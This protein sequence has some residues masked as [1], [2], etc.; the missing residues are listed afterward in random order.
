LLTRLLL[1]LVS[2]IFNLFVIRDCQTPETNESC[3]T[4]VHCLLKAYKNSVRSLS[5]EE[6]KQRRGSCS[7]YN[8]ICPA[9]C[10]I[11]PEYVACL[12]DQP[13]TAERCTFRNCNNFPI[14]KRCFHVRETWTYCCNYPE[15]HFW[16]GQWSTCSVFS[17]RL[18]ILSFSNHVTS[19]VKRRV[20][21][22]ALHCF[23]YS[24][25]VHLFI[26]GLFNEIISTPDRTAYVIKPWV[27]RGMRFA[28]KISRFL[29]FYGSVN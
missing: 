13:S 26:H 19:L 15:Q 5:L 4:T 10:R 21:S 14:K 7:I 25:R 11:V 1:V 3:I 17:V 23:W 29:F 20:V 28:V 2:M 8:H 16:P 12:Q 27:A 18:S 9:R 6:N 22:K 24:F